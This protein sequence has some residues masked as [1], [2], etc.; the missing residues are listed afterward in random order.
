MIQKVGGTIDDTE[1]VDGLIM[2][3]N[4]VKSAGGPTRMEKAK[5]GLVQFQL[6]PPKPDVSVA[7]FFL[8]FIF[9]THLEKGGRKR[10]RGRGRF[11]VGLVVFV[12]IVSCSLSSPFFLRDVVVVIGT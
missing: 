5:I 11:E 3:Q 9:L 4:A 7:F 10:E 2:S 1:L 6:S 8:I 12:W